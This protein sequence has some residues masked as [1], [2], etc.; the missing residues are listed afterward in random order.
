[1][2][3]VIPFSFT[4]KTILCSRPLVYVSSDVSN[5]Y[6]KHFHMYS[7]VCITTSRLCVFVSFVLG[8]GAAC[9]ICQ[10]VTVSVLFH[11]CRHVCVCDGC[12]SELRNARSRMCPVCR[13]E[14]TREEKVFL[15]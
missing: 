5:I 14:I 4:K 10:D 1:M 7:Y 9:V 12:A 2:Y 3:V 6:F 15:P 11:P 13:H 8:S